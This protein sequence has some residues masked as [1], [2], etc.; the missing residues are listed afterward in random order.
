MNVLINLVLLLVVAFAAV[1][2]HLSAAPLTFPSPEPL[3]DPLARFVLPTA[4]QPRMRIWADGRLVDVKNGGIVRVCLE[5]FGKRVAVH[6]KSES[7]GGR[8]FLSVGDDVVT[9]LR[10]NFVHV[11]AEVRNGQLF[12]GG[13]AE[14]RNVACE[15]EGGG[16]VE[17]SVEYGC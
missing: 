1:C 13:K 4:P 7:D 9:A 5:R 15:D 16:R 17:V 12:W 11:M 6:C 2:P 3:V 10:G 14:G 8:P